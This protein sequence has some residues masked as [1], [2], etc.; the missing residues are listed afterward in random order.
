M[1]KSKY[2]AMVLLLVSTAVL[3]D[4]DCQSYYEELDVL[5]PTP[6]GPFNGGA[7]ISIGGGAPVS[8]LAT[9]ALLDSVSYDPASPGP[10]SVKRAGQ[11]LL[12][13]GPDGSI[14]TITA[15]VAADGEPAGPGVFSVTG[16][17]KFTGG[18]GD[19][20]RSFGKAKMTGDAVVD[21]N[22]GETH[23]SA[24]LTGKICLG[25]DH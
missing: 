16:K 1:G 12:P 3:A 20:E 6:L 15:I 10:I 22:T 8:A 19:F 21:L 7:S 24:I 25:N 23:L 5:G 13:P 9:A 17:V 11:L 18:A 4:S 2:L 14:N